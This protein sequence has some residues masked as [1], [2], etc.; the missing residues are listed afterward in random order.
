MGYEC[1]IG[2]IIEDEPAKPNAR[3]VELCE[4]PNDLM[5]EEAEELV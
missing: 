2:F 3:N 4:G 5:I 1:E